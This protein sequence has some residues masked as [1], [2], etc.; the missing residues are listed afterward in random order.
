MIK[1]IN[2]WM[3]LLNNLEFMLY[4]KKEKFL[5]KLKINATFCML[6]RVLATPQELK[7]TLMVQVETMNL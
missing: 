1:D 2:L 4:V 6:E 3:M 5:P 7:H